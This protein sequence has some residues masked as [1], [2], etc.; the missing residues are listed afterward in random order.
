MAKCR[1]LYSTESFSLRSEKEYRKE[2]EQF[3]SENELTEE[4]NHFEGWYNVE[5]EQECEDFFF[6]LENSTWNNKLCVIYGEL[7]LWNGQKKMIPV[8]SKS[9]YD[10]VW[11]CVGGYENYKVQQVNGHL[12]VTVYHHDGI[13]RY[14]IE[15]LNERGVLAYLEGKNVNFESKRYHKAIEGDLFY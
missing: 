4:S 15:L 8:I 1:L 2:Y 6:N 12:F 11:Q 3:L 13:N 7:G 14:I 5:Q 9:I 10:A